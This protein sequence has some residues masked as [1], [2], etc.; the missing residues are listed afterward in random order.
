MKYIA[1]PGAFLILGLVFIFV[2]KKAIFSLLMKIEKISKDGIQTG[3]II[4]TQEEIKKTT[5]A[6][7]LMKSFD[8]IV[9]LDFETAIKKDLEIRNLDDKKAI[10]ILS[11]HLAATQLALRFEQIYI[12]IWGSQ[13]NLLKH[14]NT[15]A[16]RGDT[17]ESIKSIFYDTAEML[18]PEVYNLYTFEAYID[19]LISNTL[20]LEDNNMFKITN[21]G[22]D[23]LI[24][25]VQTGKSE[26][27]AY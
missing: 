15:R 11:R 2:F 19:F 5:S 14:L 9:L 25:L 20:V 1:W 23:F 7:E 10:I 21:L 26:A 3:N 27:R 17:K 24:Y 4:Q 22:R 8:S 13:I 12:S 18:Y 16:P 6:D